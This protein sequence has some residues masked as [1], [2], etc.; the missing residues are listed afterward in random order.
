MK[1]VNGRMMRIHVDP[2]NSRHTEVIPLPMGVADPGSRDPEI[3]LLLNSSPQSIAA[4]ILPRSP[5]LVFQFLKL[6]LL[7]LRILQYRVL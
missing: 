1:L 4:E 3:E 5:V 6:K 7:N 2:I